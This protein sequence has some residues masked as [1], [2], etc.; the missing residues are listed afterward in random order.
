MSDLSEI[1]EQWLEQQTS[2]IEGDN[3]IKL[4]SDLSEAIGYKR[5]RY[6]F[7]DPIFLFLADNP[8]EIEAVIEWIK[9]QGITDWDEKLSLSLNKES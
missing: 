1:V 5:G 8:V 3:G 6:A 4:L 2:C 9:L 7:Q